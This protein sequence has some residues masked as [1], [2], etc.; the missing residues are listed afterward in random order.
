MKKKSLFV[1]AAALCFATTALAQSD[2]TIGTYTD[3]AASSCC[4]T[5]AGAPVTIHILATLAGA[6]SGG[7]GV[8]GG[9]TGAEFRV[10][11]PAIN[12]FSFVIW[13]ASPAANTVLGS[14]LPPG[15]PPAADLNADYGVTMAFPGCQ[16]MGGGMVGD[17]VS[18]G[19]VT[20]IGGAGV[21]TPIYLKRRRPPSNQQLRDCPLLVLCDSPNFTT[22][23]VGSMAGGQVPEPIHFAG[24]VNGT[25]SPATC[26]VVAVEPTHWSAVKSL[27]R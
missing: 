10:E 6:S 24:Q 5:A 23:C 20:L 1:A 13:A 22:V 9:I 7:G 21:E 19:T 25:C 12:S 4:F 27:Y 16:P 3:A 11:I 2:G 17:H 26:G 14:P 8:M 18:L 15:T